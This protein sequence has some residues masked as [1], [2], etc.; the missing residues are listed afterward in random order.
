MTATYTRDNNFFPAAVRPA[1]LGVLAL[2]AVAMM[3]ASLFVASPVVAAPAGSAPPAAPSLQWSQ[4]GVSTPAS[5][6]DDDCAPSRQARECPS[7]TRWAHIV[8]ATGFV[9]GISICTWSVCGNPD[10]YFRQYHN[11]K[12][13]ILLDLATMTL[14]QQPGPGWW[15]VN[16][17]FIRDSFEKNATARAG[18]HR[19]DLSWSTGGLGMDDRGVVFTVTVAPTGQTIETNQSSLQIR[20][21]APGVRHTFTIVASLPNGTTKE[22]P[23]VSAT[24]LVDPNPDCLPSGAATECLSATNWAHVRISDG[25]IVTVAVCTARVC[26]DP[27]S[28]YSRIYRERGIMLVELKDT[29][30]WTGWTYLNGQFIA[31]PSLESDTNGTNSTG[32]NGQ[33]GSATSSSGSSSTS[34]TESVAG[35]APSNQDSTSNPTETSPADSGEV[36]E[37]TSDGDDGGQ[38]GSDMDAPSSIDSLTISPTPSTDG[39]SADGSE[40]VDAPV[41]VVERVIR[42]FRNLWSA[43]FSG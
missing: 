38:A 31:P 37:V 35:D 15:Y 24:P 40:I 8:E 20:S 12:G 41:T 39:D 26:G 32:T 5:G 14:E 6:E 21:L 13:I 34:P 1:V 23:V 7:A 36:S 28:D 2:G 18:I 16:G 19:V 17:S 9:D 43:I 33:A 22:A 30:A 11:N 27:Q 3:A 42:F 10:S 29:P 25:L 4:H